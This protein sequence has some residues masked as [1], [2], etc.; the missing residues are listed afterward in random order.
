MA[1]FSLLGQ[2]FICAHGGAGRGLAL[3]LSCHAAI[4]VLEQSPRLL[5]TAQ[6]PITLCATGCGQKN[7]LAD[8]LVWTLWLDLKQEGC[9][10]ELFPVRQGAG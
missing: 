10:T 5:P 9:S 1:A 6:K 8:T 7:Y 2:K 4:V 3:H